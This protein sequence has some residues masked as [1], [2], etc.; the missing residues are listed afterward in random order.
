MDVYRQRC[1]D[2]LIAVIESARVGVSAVDAED[3]IRL[4]RGDH[5]ESRV[6]GDASKARH[7]RGAPLGLYLS[8]WQQTDAQ[9]RP[10]ERLALRRGENQPSVALRVPQATISAGDDQRAYIGKWA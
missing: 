1:A 5:L 8:L 4:V 3:L 6:I 9:V 10:P 7:Q 2:A